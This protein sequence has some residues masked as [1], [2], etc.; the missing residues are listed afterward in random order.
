MMQFHN[1]WYDLTT[2]QTRHFSKSNN[3]VMLVLTVWIE[4]GDKLKDEISSQYFSTSVVWSQDKVEES[5]E[6]V[7][8]GRLTR[9]NSTCQV[10]YLHV[11]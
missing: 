4:H 9:M 6:N 8:G 3:I 7:A 5:I 10:V 1:K 2:L 11:H